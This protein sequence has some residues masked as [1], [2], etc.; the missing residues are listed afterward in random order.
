LVSNILED[1]QT[2]FAEATNGLKSLEEIEIAIKGAYAVFM[3]TNPGTKLKLQDY[4][5]ERFKQAGVNFYE[6]VHLSNGEINPVIKL[7]NSL[8]NTPGQSG[9]LDTSKFEARLQ[10]Q[11][12]R[13]IKDLL[14]N[15]FIL[16]V[17]SDGS[18]VEKMGKVIQKG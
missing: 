15:N 17:N 13:M 11:R 6:N 18:L 2:V 10:E 12:K 9:T 16:N 14:N 3:Q 1:Y 8:Y 4:V 5:R 7:Y